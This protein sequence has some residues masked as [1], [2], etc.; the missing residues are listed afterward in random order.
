[1]SRAKK[2]EESRR[3]LVECSDYAHLGAAGHTLIDGVVL[4][5]VSD[6]PFEM[7]FKCT[8]CAAVFWFE[9]LARRVGGVATWQLNAEACEVGIAECVVMQQAT[10]GRRAHNRA[11]VRT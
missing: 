9:N 7:S 5:S 4:T 8:R 11:E 2:F 6:V 3:R 10:V 1:M